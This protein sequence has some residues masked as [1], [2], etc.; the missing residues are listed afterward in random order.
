MAF[1]H[2]GNKY[3]LTEIVEEKWKL[4]KI[5]LDLYRFYVV[6]SVMI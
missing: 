2:I 1:S 3:H 4:I 5:K 6:Y